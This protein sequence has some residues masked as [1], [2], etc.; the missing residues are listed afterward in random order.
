[1]IAHQTMMAV[2]QA[3]KAKNAFRNSNPAG[4]LAGTLT[5][6][7]TKLAAGAF[8]PAFADAPDGKAAQYPEKSPQWTY[9]AAVEP[10]PD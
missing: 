10:R 6:F 4:W 2:I 9:K 1:M 7:F 3:I 8:F 5:I